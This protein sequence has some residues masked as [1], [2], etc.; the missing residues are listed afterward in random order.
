MQPP[1]SYS[2]RG[3]HSSGQLTGKPAGD[4]PDYRGR[5]CAVSRGHPGRPKPSSPPGDQLCSTPW[6]L[7]S[8]IGNE[9]PWTRTGDVQAIGCILHSTQSTFPGCTTREPL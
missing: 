9:I 6:E 5:Q 7:P 4:R 2:I 8:T 1:R 3:Q